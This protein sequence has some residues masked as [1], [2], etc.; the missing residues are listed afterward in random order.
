MSASLE[1]GLL[2]SQMTCPIC[3]EDRVA[4]RDLALSPSVCLAERASP[5][6]PPVWDASLQPAC[7]PRPE[8]VEADTPEKPSH[9]GQYA[10]AAGWLCVS[11]G[12]DGVVSAVAVGAAFGTLRE[13]TALRSVALC[14][15]CV[16][17]GM[18]ALYAVLASRGRSIGLFR[19][20]G[21][22]VLRGLAAL[23]S[24]AACPAS[25]CAMA[26][27]LTA[28]GLGALVAVVAI[29]LPKPPSPVAAAVATA[30]VALA[31]VGAGVGIAAA[32]D[33]LANAGVYM[34]IPA[35]IM[36]AL[37]AC[38]TQQRVAKDQVG[39]AAA[40]PVAA[41]LASLRRKR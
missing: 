13:T 14:F 11:R 15:A 16:L 4:P 30:A 34:C 8:A 9:R 1:P 22:V 18:Y 31:G 27:W 6:S 28:G 40:M 38:L 32:L 10:R 5:D 2:D 41:L 3:P 29:A 7:T 39:G 21:V 19:L 35:A 23:A 20:V 36:A 24:V 33:V 25:V 12:A 26:A 17:W 37:G